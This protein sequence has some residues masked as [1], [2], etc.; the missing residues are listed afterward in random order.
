M[1]VITHDYG[2]P[3]LVSTVEMPEDNGFLPHTLPPPSQV[4][5]IHPGD[6]GYRFPPAGSLLLLH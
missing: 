4:P 3:S 2:I 1:R 6:G 5:L